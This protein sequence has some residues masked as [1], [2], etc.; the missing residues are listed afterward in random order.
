[1]LRPAV[2][3]SVCLGV[4]FTLNLWADII[5]CLKVTVLSLWAGLS[6]ER[7]GL[8][9]VGHC[10]QCL[11]HYQR[12]SI[13]YIVHVTCFMYMQYILDLCQHRLRTTDHA[14]IYA[15]TANVSCVCVCIYIYIKNKYR[16]LT[17][18]VVSIFQSSHPVFLGWFGETRL[19][20]PT[21]S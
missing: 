10:H 8:S 5:F 18:L 20:N 11:V 7:L 21:Q 19:S 4:K 13:I 6:D 9:P 14:K 16:S 12:F 17:N 1:M 3:Q 15:T 2:G